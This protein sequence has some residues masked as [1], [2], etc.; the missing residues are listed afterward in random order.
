MDKKMENYG[1]VE[2]DLWINRRRWHGEPRIYCRI[3]EEIS[4]DIPEDLLEY[5][6]SSL[7]FSV[8]TDILGDPQR[9]LDI[10]GY[11]LWANSQM[12]GFNYVIIDIIGLVCHN[13]SL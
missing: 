12:I 4:E 1:E 6:K 10:L 5:P 3:S 7:R 2:G 8:L 11:L 13:M 9:Y